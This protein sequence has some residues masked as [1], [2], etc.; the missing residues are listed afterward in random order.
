MKISI[1]IPI[2]KAEH[3]IK[4]CLQSV[5]NQ[6]FTDYEIV[7]V[8][9]ASPDNSLQIAEQFLLDKNIEH[10]SIIHKTNKKQ[11]ETRNT[12]IKASRGTYLMF[13]D[14]DD[15]LAHNRVLGEFY[16]AIERENVDFVSANNNVVCNAIIQKDTYTKG[17][18]TN[19]KLSHFD[20]L[21]GLLNTEIA[22]SPWN[23]L[24]KKEFIIQNNLYFPKGMTIED[25]LWSFN[26]CRKAKSCY[27]LASYNYNY[28]Y[29]SNSESVHANFNQQY[30]DDLYFSIKKI[31]QIIEKDNNCSAKNA[32][33]YAYFI[34]KKTSIDILAIPFIMNDKTLWGQHYKKLREIYNK[35]ILNTYEKRFI[36][37]T[38]LAY[39]VFMER[40]KPRSLL[41]GKYYLK[42]VTIVNGLNFM[43][44]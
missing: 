44:I 37:P 12:G 34:V 42:L 28:H 41:R 19:K 36:L 6:T 24:L 22:V 13:I 39:F 26:L 10:Q 43:G 2:Y 18:D 4:R 35:S 15:E 27:C 25:R 31:L 11:S 3:C 8:D 29:S 9:D 7:L 14:N 23:K 1:I 30:I 40:I 32:N 20:V 38:E 16:E 5:I 21:E 33:A 17:I